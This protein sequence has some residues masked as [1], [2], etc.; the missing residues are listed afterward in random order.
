[1][2]KINQQIR[3]FVMGEID[4][5]RRLAEDGQSSKY[6]TTRQPNQKE[7]LAILRKGGYYR[8]ATLRSDATANTR[9]LN[10]YD[11]NDVQVRDDAKRGKAAKAIKDAVANAR[12]QVMLTATTSEQADGVLQGLAKKLKP[13]TDHA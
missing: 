11:F 8:D 9:L 3:K 10:A 6:T 13:Y 12:R 7:K 1:M 2:A 4:K 5:L